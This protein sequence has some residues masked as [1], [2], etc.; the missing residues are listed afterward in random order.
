MPATSSGVRYSAVWVAVGF[1]ILARS[2]PRQ[3]LLHPQQ[4]VDQ[5]AAQEPPAASSGKPQDRTQLPPPADTPT[6]A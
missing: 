6:A 1:V 2:G 4:I 3:V 5:S